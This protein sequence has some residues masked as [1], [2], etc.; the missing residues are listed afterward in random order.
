M[1][2]KKN[3]K[4]TKESFFTQALMDWNGTINQRQMPWKGE[5]DPYKIW[6]SEVMLQQTQVAQGLDYYNRFIQAF[7]TI[8]ALANA[9]DEAVFKLWEGLGYYSR[10]RNLIYTAR[11]IAFELGGYFPTNYDDI[12]RLKGVGPYTAA[13]IA[14]FAFN[15]PYAVVDGNVFRVLARFFGID[16]PTDSTAGKKLF[17]ALAQQLLYQQDPGK[18]NQAIMDFGATVCKPALPN[19]NQCVLSNQ[20]V[21]FQNSQVN[22]LPIK[23]KTILRK[24]RWFYYFIFQHKGTIGIQQ[25]QQKDIW[26]GLHEFYLIESTAAKQWDEPAIQSW[27]TN[28]MGINN[29]QVSYCSSIQTQ[30]LTHQQLS[31]QFIHIQ[32]N[33]IPAQLK[34]LSWV[35]AAQMNTL[36]F[37]RMITAYMDTFNSK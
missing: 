15:L 29:A 20:C 13:A 34:G 31:G 4:H 22:V 27:L 18:Y 37:P 14:S 36:A 21:A 19:C 12:L 9:K 8:V 35:T 25:R 26:H 32:L 17:A 30:N 23:T 1:A 10:C 24:K 28:Q 16:I 2:S 6:L 11:Y 7:P 5:K 33:Q 3:L